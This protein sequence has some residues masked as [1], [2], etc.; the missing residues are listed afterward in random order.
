LG[1]T[2]YDSLQAKVTKRLSHGLSFFSTFSWSKTL[3]IGTERDPNPGTTG[4]ASFNDVF[5]R[6]NQKYLSIYDS[7]LQTTMAISYITPAPR[8]NKWL[9]WVARDWTFGT[10]LAYRSGLPMPVPTATQSTGLS[11]LLFQSTFANRVPGEPLF[12]ADL[13]C[14]C[15]DPNKTYVLNPKA[16]TQPDVGTFGTSAAYYGD[17]RKQR[18]PS[19]S[20]SLGRTFR[21]T[22]KANFN[23]RIEF[24]NI[25]NRAYFNDPRNSDIAETKSPLPNGNV[26]PNSG[27]GAINTTTQVGGAG[28]AAVVNIAPRNGVLVGRFTF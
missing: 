13:N 27:F 3:T 8:I 10:A 18:R 6:A 28:L 15:F 9:S 11:S 16:W 17:Y 14:H 4:N 20:M 25:F 7:P 2:W 24:N 1:N 19:E 22:E 12:L 5:N 23:I 26:N 21:I